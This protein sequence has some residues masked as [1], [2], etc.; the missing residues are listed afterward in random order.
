MFTPRKCFAVTSA[1]LLLGFSSLVCAASSADKKAADALEKSLPSLVSSQDYR[2]ASTTAMRLASA[3]SSLGET[4]AACAAL[5]QSLEYY[6]KALLKE[7]GASEAAV[8]SIND[9]SDG[10]A[11]VRAKFGCSRS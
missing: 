5:S 6:R 1:S 2:S 4:A 10:M 11:A 9:D 7:T 3:R 8:S